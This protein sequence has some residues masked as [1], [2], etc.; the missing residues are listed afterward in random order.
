MKKINGTTLIKVVILLAFFAQMGETLLAPAMNDIASSFPDIS[1]ALFNLFLTGPAI[2]CVIGTLLCGI[3]VR[4][5]S[6]KT[7]LVCS[8][9]LFTIVTSGGALVDNMLYMV[10][11]R[12]LGGL[13]YG[14]S[15][16]VIMGLI[17]ELFADESE[18][19][20]MMG[21]TGSAG[22]AY[23]VILSL[24]GGYLAARNWHYAFYPYLFGI[25]ILILI[26]IFVPRTPPE[27]KADG[28]SAEKEKLPLKKLVPIVLAFA[29]YGALF[30][31][32][33]YYVSFYLA[34]TNLGDA[35]VAGII[36][37]VGTASGFLA[38][39]VFAFVYMHLKK[40]TPAVCFL[41]SALF[42]IIIAFPSNIW[43]LG[44]M[45]FV[46]NFA[47][48]TLNSYYFMHSSMIV[49]PGVMTL[50]MA[51]L[52]AAMNIGGFFSAYIFDT[53]K[54]VLRLETVASVYLYIGITLAIGAVISVILAVRSG[55]GA[56][57]EVSQDNPGGM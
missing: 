2:S 4:F 47:Y 40:L 37:S 19:S 15:G 49:P 43:I 39:L 25:P 31:I 48:I 28:Q 29:T 24:V 7:I 32:S 55:S 23:G 12:L 51:I 53:Y 11:M 27:G 16:T 21:A 18:R 10:T 56:A 45:T 33:L 36:A 14:A 26:I 3:L 44:I 50:T 34:E 20:F 54:A 9:I 1:S 57:T 17:A 8:Y 6:K 5:I 41:L 52:T 22:A 35:S 42:F 38:G 30:F 13:A 46:G